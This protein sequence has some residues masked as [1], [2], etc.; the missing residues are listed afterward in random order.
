MRPSGVS[1]LS[2]AGCGVILTSNGPV[3]C[4]VMVPFCAGGEGFWEKNVES[5]AIRRSVVEMIV[6]RYMQHLT[7]L[8]KADSSLCSE[9]QTIK[10]RGA[11][12]PE[13]RRSSE[14]IT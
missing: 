14:C 11:W 5:S 8:R 4:L 12:I 3:A 13:S 9:L 2:S 6:W 7:A 1:D 10:N